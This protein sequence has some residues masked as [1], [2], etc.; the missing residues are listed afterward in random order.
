[1][2][3]PRAEI[4]AQ[5]G[6]GPSLVLI[7]GFGSDR[8]SWAANA[9]AL[10]DAATVWA[11]DLPGHGAATNDVGAGDPA[12]L[13]RAVA[14]AVTDL[15]GPLTLVGHS[16]G[17]AVALHLAAIAPGLVRRLVLIAPAGLGQALDHGF[18][19]TFPELA[20]PEAAQAMLE[21]LVERK[22]LI[23]PAMVAHVLATLDRPGRR[24]AL[25]KI[26]GA[27]AEAAPPPIPAAVPVDL[28]W[29]EADAINPLPP[30]G[31]GFA[32][33]CL[34]TLPGSGHLPQVEAAAKVNAV[35]RAALAG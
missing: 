24:D 10:T 3:T 26:A 7:H 19:D 33:A 21:R 34:L 15:P 27:L 17:G 12:T 13:A 14:A 23:V 11:V 1:M 28:I 35:I 20:T 5:G 31:P 25:R 2:T 29:G 30:Q 8:Y 4:Y 18:L 16:L 22:R 32:P 6:T 9:P